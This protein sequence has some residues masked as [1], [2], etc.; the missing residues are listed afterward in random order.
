MY[1]KKYVLEKVEEFGAHNSVY[2]NI[3]GAIC[4]SAYFN[5]GERGCFI[6]E[7]DDWL[8]RAHKI[9][10]SAIKDVEYNDNQVIVTTR[11]TRL[12]FRL[13]DE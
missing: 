2:D 7:D 4:Y 10:T 9:I 6:Y 1:N 13:V 8:D 11:N 12:T 3:E 5:I